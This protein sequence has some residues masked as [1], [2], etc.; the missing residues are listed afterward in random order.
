MEA[1]RVV[2]DILSPRESQYHL[3]PFNEYRSSHHGA[4]LKSPQYEKYYVVCNGDTNL[5]A[6]WMLCP[7]VITGNCTGRKGLFEINTKKGRTN[8]FGHH[9]N[10]HEKALSNKHLLTRELDIQCRC[11]ISCLT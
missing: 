7:Y 4:H 6:G 8:R 1:E 10:E 11:S 9:L 2:D 5:Y 3:V